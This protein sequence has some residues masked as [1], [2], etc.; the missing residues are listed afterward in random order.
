M[1]AGMT[2]Q[3]GVTAA[4]MIAHRPGAMN[5][6]MAAVTSAGDTQSEGIATGVTIAVI[7][8]SMIAA[9]TGDTL[10]PATGIPS[11]PCT[12]LPCVVFAYLD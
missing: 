3:K 9:M 2:G 8:G 1:G 6:A 5:A 11:C 12:V 7:L 4:D 10:S